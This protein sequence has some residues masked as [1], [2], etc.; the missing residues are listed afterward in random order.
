MKL[1]QILLA[2]ALMG[3]MISCHRQDQYQ[4]TL[5]TDRI[6]YDVDIKSPDPDFDW[7]VQN[8][9]GSKREVFIRRVMDAA[10]EG[11]V[12]TFSYFNEPLTPEQ[13]K[14]IGFQADTLTFQRSTPPYEF[15]DTVV[16]RRINLQDITRFRF[17]EEWYMDPESFMI[18]KKVIGIAP[19][20]R[21]YTESGEL[22][23]YMPLFWIYFDENYP[24]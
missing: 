20:L 24:K 4:G 3:L 18:S 19:V 16:E 22:M 13:V 12:R 17:L 15:Y 23:G 6:Q 11:K 9:E 5:I 8:I 1:T 10:Y 7:W 2:C 14:E 21:R